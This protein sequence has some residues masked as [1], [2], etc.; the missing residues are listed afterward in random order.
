MTVPRIGVTLG[1]PGGIGPEIVLKALEQTDALPAAS[2]VLFGDPRI[3]V[4]EARAVAPAADFRSWR[5]GASLEPGRYLVEVPAA[6]AVR[7]RPGPEAGN[8]K[9]SFGF[10]EAAVEAARSGV[11]DAVVTAPISKASWALAGLPWR[12]HTE[13]LGHFYPEAV[14]SFWSDRL[15]VALLSHHIPLSEALARVRKDAL[16]AYFRSLNRGA[17]RVQDG[18][19]EF[20]VPGLNP[21]AGEDGLIGWEEERE[22]RPAI[23]E[24]R[25]EGIEIDGPYAP[26]TVFRMALGR[27]EKMVAAL[28]HDQ[29]LIAFKL[30]SFETGVNATLGLPFIRT[31][32]D[33][34]TAFGIAGKGLADPRSMMEAIRLAVRFSAIAS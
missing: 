21:H 20:L 10:F 24:A 26:D 22:V 7:I 31:S 28:Y 32:P 15:R 30:E 1:D 17:G 33:H 14:M 5:A 6:D 19:R 23:A 16:L 29:G 27:P 8:G 11:L 34:G 13:Y 25:A 4:E 9:A 12:G 3:V 2:Y 18:P